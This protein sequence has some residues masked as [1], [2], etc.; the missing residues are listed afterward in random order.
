MN[1]RDLNAITAILRLLQK[2]IDRLV[3]EFNY[4]EAD[5]TDLIKMAW[6]NIGNGRKEIT[7]LFSVEELKEA[8][9]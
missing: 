5:A 6:N 9:F 2:K 7:D 1:K 4:T 8:G 3:N